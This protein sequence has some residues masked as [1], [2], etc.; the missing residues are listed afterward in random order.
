MEHAQGRLLPGVRNLCRVLLCAVLLGGALVGGVAY[1]RGVAA[2]TPSTLRIWYGTDDPTEA[3]W[4][5]QLA[6][7]FEAQHHGVKVSLT[8]YG[9]DDLNAKMQV[10]LNGTNPPDLVYTTPRGPGL[11]A[12]VRAGK[13]LDLT[14]AARRRGWAA[15]LRPGLLADYNRLLAANGSKRDAGKIYAVP[16]VIAAVAVLYN[17]QLFD[18]LHLRVPRTLSEL[19]TA[20]ARVKKAGYTPLG[21]GNADGWVGD[22]W[23]LTMVNA[24]VAPAELASALR[25]SSSFSFTR[26]PFRAAAVTL[27][28][29]ANRSYFTRDFGGL[30]AQDSVETFFDGKTAMQLVSSTE[31]SQILSLARQSKVRVGIFAFPSA[32]QGQPPVMPQSGYAGWAIPRNARNPGAALAFIDLVTSATTG[33]LLLSR[34]M[35]PA[36]RIDTRRARLAAPFQQQY[37]TALDGATPGVYLDSA[38]IPNIN[39]T[40][41]ANVQLLLQG[42]EAPD[43]LT[44]S[45]QQVYASHGVKASATR[46]DGEF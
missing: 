43:F 39:A 29:W 7:G 9:L 44:R 25:L 36:H 34:G 33:D 6:R 27:Q 15:R 22:D 13:L 30:D 18:K 37:I 2:A 28:D 40:M 41:E 3:S 11:P 32:R 23:Y 19:Q 46:T 45:L 20:L 1:G 16:Y 14:T 42:Y 31:N 21:L 26:P 35:L 5:Q 24:Q 12:Y 8:T 4:A 17:Q 38:P 10:A